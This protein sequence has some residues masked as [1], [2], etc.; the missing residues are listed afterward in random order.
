M[1]H[2]SPFHRFIIAGCLVIAVSAPSLAQQAG[3]FYVRFD[4]GP[5]FAQDTDVKQFIGP[6]PGLKLEFDPGVHLSAAG[7]YQVTDWF[8]AELQ[9]GFSI[10]GVDKFSPSSNI[11][12]RD[13]SFGNFPMMANAVFQYPCRCGFIPFVGG[14]LGASISTFFAD[15]ISDGTV[16]VDGTDSDA[17]F[18]YQVFG[19]LRYELSER[20]DL[21]LTYKYFVSQD[22]SWDVE[23][24]YGADGKIEFDQ[25]PT[26]IIAFTFTLRF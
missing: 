11:R 16:I 2:H 6:T 26:H 9:T 13:S 7:G 14:G 22:P 21:G 24:R 5:A 19:G 1:K 23:V 4:T 20:M 10:N 17:V 25:I 3:H 12:V 8:A 18:A 15:D